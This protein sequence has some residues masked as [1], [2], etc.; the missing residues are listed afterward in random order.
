MEGRLPKELQRLPFQRI[1]AEVPT[2]VT[3]QT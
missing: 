3:A 2:L 1:L